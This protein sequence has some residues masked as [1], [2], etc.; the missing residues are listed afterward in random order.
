MRALND[1]QLKAQRDNRNR[2][3]IDPGSLK[4]WADAYHAQ[5]APS[6]HVGGDAQVAQE[7]A[8]TAH[9]AAPSEPPSAITAEL[10]ELRVEVGRQRERA[11][12]AEAALSEVRE[13]LS[14][15]R[16]T[17][18][19]LRCRLDR[20]EERMAALLVAP[21]KREQAS[22]WSRLTSWKPDA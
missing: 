14:R 19:D 17:V 22:W 20:S 2:W 8:H 4:A 7:D 1:H 13:A 12:T 16:E 10:V 21:Q 3:R 18:D 5:W 6:E 11:A 9:P 15:E